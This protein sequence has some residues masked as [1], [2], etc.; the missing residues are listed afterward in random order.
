L[1]LAEVGVG[2]P[3]FEPI[4]LDGTVEVRRAGLAYRFHPGETEDSWVQ[5][6]FIDGAWVPYCTYNLR[7]ATPAERESAYQRHHTPGVSWVIGSLTMI[8]CEDDEVFVLRNDGFTHFTPDGKRTEPLRDPADY[9][10]LAAGVFHLPALPIKDGLEA[11]TELN[12]A[13]PT[14]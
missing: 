11:W 7:G 13:A 3:F 10:R 1:A 5:D 14:A 6:R 4:P 12:S 9:A 2:A 8:R